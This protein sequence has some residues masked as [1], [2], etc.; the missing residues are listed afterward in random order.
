M[1]ERP[2]E[3]DLATV[4]SE[5]ILPDRASGWDMFTRATTWAIAIIVVLLIALK[6]LFG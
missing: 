2:D 5:D 6:L 4:T 1:A 3:F